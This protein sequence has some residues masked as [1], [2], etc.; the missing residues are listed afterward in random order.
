MTLRTHFLNE[1]EK[2]MTLLSIITSKNYFLTVQRISTKKRGTNLEHRRAL[3][4]FPSF[5]G[6]I[7]VMEKW[8]ESLNFTYPCRFIDVEFKIHAAHSSDNEIKRSTLA[9]HYCNKKG[10]NSH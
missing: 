3:Q 9:P 10:N 8:S 5:L 6:M 7:L 1:E 2:V 4:I